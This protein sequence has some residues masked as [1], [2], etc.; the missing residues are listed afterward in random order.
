[1]KAKLEYRD[2]SSSKFWEIEVD[3]AAHVVRFGKIGTDGQ[4]KRKPFPSE[5]AALADAKKLVAEKTKKGYVDASGPAPPAPTTEPTEAVAAPYPRGGLFLKEAEGVT[6]NAI[7]TKLRE[8]GKLSKANPASLFGFDENGRVGIAVHPGKNGFFATADTADGAQGIGAGV[9][10]RPAMM[11]NHL[12]TDVVWFRIYSP[13]TAVAVRFVRASDQFKTIAGDERAILAWLGSMNLPV[14]E[15]KPPSRAGKAATQIAIEYEATKYRTGPDVEVAR[16]LAAASVE[17]DAGDASAMAKRVR[18]LGDDAKSLALGLVRN[19]TSDAAFT[20]IRKL[21]AEI[22]AGALTP[23]AQPKVV[24]LEEEVLRTGA[25]SAAFADAKLF[26]ACVTRLDEIESEAE[27]RS[28][29]AQTN[30]LWNLGAALGSAGKDAEAHVCFAKILRR[31]EDNA[32]WGIVNGALSSLLKGR[33]GKIALS[34]DDGDVVARAE[35]RLKDLGESAQDAIL[36]NLG[37]V[38]ARAGDAARALDRLKRCRTIR[39]QNQNPEKDTDLES[40]W[41]NPAFQALLAPKRK[42]SNPAGVTIEEL[43]LSAGATEALK[44]QKIA[45]VADIL[46]SSASAIPAKQRAEVSAV[47]DERF[48]LKWGGGAAQ[49]AVED[50]EDEST[51]YVPPKKRAV[52]RQAIALV[53]EEENALV[54]R[55]GGLPNVPKNFEWPETT[56]RPMDFVLQ[57]VG[58]KAGGEIDIGDVH[59]VQ[60]FADLEGDFYDPHWHKV[61]VHREA[62]T[63]VPE[64]P[65][66]LE[67]A[68]IRVMRFTPGADDSA[69]RDVIDPDNEE[70]L[71]RVGI[72]AED[73]EA[74]RDHA[75]CD[76]IR[77]IPVGANLDP[78]VQDTNGKPMECLLELV[79]YDDWFLWTLFVNKDYSE[80]VLQIVRG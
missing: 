4:T 29:W 74:A 73:H 62:C 61:L 5:E 56:K 39:Q 46:R 14:A 54:S 75:W 17:L 70:E 28:E 68:P 79:R 1:V 59:V 13:E 24:S 20:G 71:E 12:G 37:C 50:E 8:D 44:K 60:V 25:W 15:A 47:L 21:A 80:A 51:D 34:G 30:G 48:G 35:R 2:S 65:A 26:P 18:K 64:A 36:Y 58:K 10:S 72:S 16:E 33:K 11:S 53:D 66:G 27:R 69:L 63:T 23:R 43:E 19:A 57:L 42:S 67:P 41:K 6:V 49:G 78:N 22:A 7:V 38:Y 76:K 45:T 55:I 52:P 32:H 77:G 3:G 40:L 31:G 9:W